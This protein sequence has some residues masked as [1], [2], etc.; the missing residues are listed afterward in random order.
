[1]INE[2]VFDTP[3]A[4][5]LLKEKNGEIIHSSFTQEKI[6]RTSN[7]TLINAQR[8]IVEYF[9]GDRKNFTIKVNPEG[10]H[11]QKKIWGQL[12]QIEY[13]F[14]KYYSDIAKN[15]AS[16]PRAVGNACGANKC[17]LIIPC[18]RVLSKDNGR[19]G[20]SSFGGLVHKD[21]LLELEKRCNI[22]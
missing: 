10:T 8:E 21:R 4:R 20:Y 7:Q 12:L 11:Y 5:M 13:G 14:T 1:M 9:E 17:L 19:S 22:K 18:H 6:I 3:L 2:C 16:S 15:L